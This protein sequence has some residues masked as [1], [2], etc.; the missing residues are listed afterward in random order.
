LFLASLLIFAWALFG[1][2]GEWRRAAGPRAWK[3]PEDH[4]A[5]PAFKTEWWYFTG[6]LTD[7]AGARYGYELTFFRQ[8]VRIDPADPGNP[9]SVRDVYLAHF[10]V[11]DGGRGVFRTE[12]SLS[13]S[14][15]GL[16][17]ART[18]ALDVWCLDWSAKMTGSAVQLNARR[19]GAGISLRLEPRKPVVLHGVNGLSRKGPEA[20]ESS[21][22]VSFTDCGTSG[23]IT[24]ANGRAPIEVTG[25][26]W[27][28]HEFSSNML[29]KDQAGWDWV[30]LH[31]SDG[32]D[33]MV[34]LIRR[35]DG[36]ADNV[37]GTLV[38][39]GGATRS[40]ARADI[41]L[42]TLDRWRS[43]K[44]GGDY[45]SRWRLV[46]PGAGIDLVITPLLADQE[47]VGAG[48]P[49]LVYWEG[50][51]AAEG[52]SNGRPIRA[53]GYVELTGYAG[54]LKAIFNHK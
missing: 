52:A 20:G 25:T 13:R 28:D 50:A 12:S 49:N 41:S 6:N 10:A 1:Q 53:E 7:G 51:V 54:D 39:P 2:G 35:A 42:T 24:P 36:A 43:P 17:G 29:A 22:Y 21:Y 4:G 38:E 48:L 5:H 40:L 18:D 47:L 3:F 37:S 32:R 15:P 30:S 34:Y 46:I 27:F 9:W 19:N 26:S 16:A 14:G 11:T 45:P 44:S 8:G 31:L 23:A 33:L